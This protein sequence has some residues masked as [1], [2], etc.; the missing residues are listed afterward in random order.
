MFRPE[1]PLAPR[2]PVFYEAWQA[3]VLAIADTMV[4]A[5]R[6]SA[7]D[8]AETL[9]A[10]LRRAEAGGR[11]DTTT[12]YYEA[13]LRALERLTTEA[14]PITEAELAARKLDWTP[15]VDFEELVERMYEHDLEW[16]KAKAGTG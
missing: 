4:R 6:F 8:W 2:D 12:T 10:E 15:K 11:P 13:A 1:N 3:Q 16:E 5:G 14:T 9:G 7:T